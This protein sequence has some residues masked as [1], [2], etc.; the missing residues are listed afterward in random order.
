[1]KKAFI[2][3]WCMAMLVAM[4]VLLQPGAQVGEANND[5]LMVF[6]QENNI[7]QIGPEWLDTDWNYRTPIVINNN[8]G[9]TLTDYQIL[10]KLDDSNFDFS[11]AK[12]GGSDVRFTG[13]DGETELDYW[14]E[15]WSKSNNLAYIWVNVS[16]LPMGTTQIYIYYDNDDPKEGNISSGSDTFIFF[17]DNWDQFALGG[18]GC[19]TDYPWKCT[20]ITNPIL[21]TGDLAISKTGILSFEKYNFKALGY[22]AIFDSQDG[23]LGGFYN[24]DNLSQSLIMDL[25]DD[26]IT[27]L[28]L[29][30]YVLGD[31]N[32]NIIERVGDIHNHHIYEI[33][34][35]DVL[36]IADID[37]G[38]STAE[39]TDPEQVPDGNLSIRFYSPPGF[40]AIL[41]VDWVYVRNYIYPEPGVTFGTEQGLSDLKM[42][43]S[44]SP[45]PVYAGE[46]LTYQLTVTNTSQIDAPGVVVTETLPAEVNFVSANPSVCTGS[47]QLICNLGSINHEQSANITVVVDTTIDGVITNTAE[48]GSL[49]YDPDLETNIAQITT[50]VSSSADI[51]ITLQADPEVVKPEAL[52]T[53]DLTLTNLGPSTVPTASA[54]LT[55]PVGIAFYSAPSNICNAAN[56]IVTCTLSDINSGTEHHILII[57]IVQGTA[58]GNLQAVANMSS[59]THDPDLANNISIEETFVDDV[60]PEVS[61][62]SPVGNE[63]VY[64]TGKDTITLTASAEDNYGIDKVVFT[65]WDH[66]WNDGQGHYVSIGTVTT[67]PYQAIADISQLK[68]GELYQFYAEA[69]DFAGNKSIRRRIFIVKENLTFLPIIVSK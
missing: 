13:N 25:W 60:L 4:A 57:G 26:S 32:D 62:L 46:A 33:R 68:P 48:V 15:S 63:H 3:A 52:I 35:S 41:Y 49:A 37:H 5:A 18:E 24:Q 29:R 64:Y 47:S 69:Y 11:K 36:S 7:E 66:L 39:S 51:S 53:Y 23:Q 40:N 55:L 43:M 65:M 31:P 12:S 45:D 14:I 50:T 21:S 16:V 19:K 17:E 42:S 8:S 6:G 28:Y 2:L 34:W 1:V 58:S 9:G 30:N 54:V 56:G 10:I 59:D 67:E 22:R 20:E 61:W 38:A 27:D 44:D